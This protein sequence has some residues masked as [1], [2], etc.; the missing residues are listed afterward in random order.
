MWCKKRITN[1][2]LLVRFKD[3]KHRFYLEAVC[4]EPISNG[5][6]CSSCSNLKPQTKTQ[7]V[8]TFD[9]GF[10]GEEYPPTSHIFESPWYIAKVKAYGPPS[11]EE[12]EL[13]MEAKKRATTGTK[14]KAMKDLVAALAKT[15]PVQKPVEALQKVESLQLQPSK[16]LDQPEKKIEST[17]KETPTKVSKPRTY[18]KKKDDNQPLK[19]QLVSEETIQ[20]K[21]IT[22]IPETTK[23]AETMDE[24]I[25]V[26]QVLRVVLK[27]FTYNDVTYWRDSERDKLY[28]KTKD[29]KKGD[30]VGR[31]DSIE[32]KL[33]K[34]APDSDED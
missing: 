12:L 34:E 33:V 21:S 2:T 23:M 10:V 11:N 22:T 31:W 15:S 29:G 26:N 18:R 24:P 5:V 14:T 13:A 8:K 3:G 4:G 30:Y 19:E 28:K 16:I 9:H 7:D 27:N 6:L 1:Q 17:Q 25:K 20:S 32:H